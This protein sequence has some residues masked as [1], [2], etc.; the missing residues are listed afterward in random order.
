MSEK[1]HAHHIPFHWI[2][3][4]FFWRHAR[5]VV[6]PAGLNCWIYS[7]IFLAVSK[8]WMLSIGR[9][10][11]LRLWWVCNALYCILRFWLYFSVLF[12]DIL[13]TFWL[14]FIQIDWE[15]GRHACTFMSLIHQSPCKGLCVF[16]FLYFVR[17]GHWPKIV[18]SWK[19]FTQFHSMRRGAGRVKP[20]GPNIALGQ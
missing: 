3:D 14:F 4:S 19:R 8:L 20:D 9:E 5:G 15:I 13:L 10:R 1:I 7:I 6:R 12:T 16:F 17:F 2:C 18:A 11:A